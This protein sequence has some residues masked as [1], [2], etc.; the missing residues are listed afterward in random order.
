MCSCW[1]PWK[2]WSD[3]PNSCGTETRE[4]NR[5]CLCGE[6]G[7]GPSELGPGCLTD[8]TESELCPGDSCQWDC[9]TE[10]SECIGGPEAATG[11]SCGPSNK[12][13][14]RICECPENAD[15]PFLLQNQITSDFLTNFHYFLL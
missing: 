4:R 10:W 13:R 8:N 5:D 11:P 12:E 6:A 3:C 15:R 14:N 2:P 9:W 1:G 7:D